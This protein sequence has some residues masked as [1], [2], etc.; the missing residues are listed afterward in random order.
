MAKKMAE[1]KQ[2]EYLS[3]ASTGAN[4]SIDPQRRTMRSYALTVTELKSIDMNFLL[5]RKLESIAAVFGG[6]VLTTIIDAIAQ[7]NVT[8]VGW[9]ILGICSLVGTLFFVMSRS[10]M[11]I[12]TSLLETAMGVDKDPSP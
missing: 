7:G 3:L 10:A 8:G 2:P 11:K 12:R 9:A 6:A 4:L 5:A 1:Q